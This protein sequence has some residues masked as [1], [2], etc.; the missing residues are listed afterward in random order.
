[1]SHQPETLVTP[2]FS[3]D[4]DWA[5]STWST[6]LSNQTRKEAILARKNKMRLEA[7]LSCEGNSNFKQL[8]FF[9]YIASRKDD[10]GGLDYIMSTRFG[11]DEFGPNIR[12]I[13]RSLKELRSKK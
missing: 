8:A 13:K 1:M 10:Y 12:G 5:K 9:L 7:I 2:V 3:L 11:F 4:Q 6:R